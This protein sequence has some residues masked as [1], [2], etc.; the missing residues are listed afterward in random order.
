MLHDIKRH[1]SHF[2]FHALAKFQELSFSRRCLPPTYNEVPRMN[3][4]TEITGRFSER[5]IDERCG[6]GKTLILQ[7]PESAMII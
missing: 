3:A 1:G 7:N 2:V 6:V 5:Q 4:V